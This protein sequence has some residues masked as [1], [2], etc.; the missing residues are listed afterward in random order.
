MNISGT[1]NSISSCEALTG[2]QPQRATSIADSDE[3]NA[4]RPHHAHGGGH[5]R[6]AVQQAMQSLGL[7]MPDANAT[8]A[9]SSTSSDTGSDASSASSDSRVRQ[10]MHQ[11]MHSLFEAVKNE[12]TTSASSTSSGGSDPQSN[13]ASGL[14][15]LISQV[16][17]G[18]APSDL[19]ASFSQLA[20]D[21]QASGA[22]ASSTDGSSTDASSRVQAT[23]QAFLTHLQQDL[24]YGGPSASAGGS[25]I[26]TQVCAARTGAAN[27]EEGQRPALP[28][29]A[30]LPSSSVRSCSRTRMLPW[31]T[32]QRWPRTSNNRSFSSL[33]SST[34]G[35]PL[36]QA[37]PTSR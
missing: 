21:L 5:M 29:T 11:F 19:Q 36:P 30:S 34:V 26:T 32:R 16:S 3:G 13:F 1:L 14:S 2:L 7:S 4:G 24:G 8:N 15:S 20:S 27:D 12:A 33:A 18:S 6:Q 25:L 28:L 23:L 31:Y 17:A 22:T 10:D 9:N 37:K 35:K